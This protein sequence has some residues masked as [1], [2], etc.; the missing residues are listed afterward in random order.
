LRGWWRT[1]D[2]KLHGLLFHIWSHWFPWRVPSMKELRRLG[3]DQRS[4]KVILEVFLLLIWFMQTFSALIVN[5][6]RFYFHFR[7]AWVIGNPLQ[8]YILSLVL[9]VWP[10]DKKPVVSLYNNIFPLLALSAYFS[11]KLI[12]WVEFNCHFKLFIWHINDFLRRYHTSLCF[13]YF[14]LVV[15]QMGHFVR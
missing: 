9:S 2:Q 12:R 6:D 1:S 8:I 15:K 3:S 4:H 14:R 7:N 11:L 13:S 5:L 10:F